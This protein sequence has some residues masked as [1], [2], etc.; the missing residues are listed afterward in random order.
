M[1]RRFINKIIII[2]FCFRNDD[3]SAGLA[4]AGRFPW[5]AAGRHRLLRRQRAGPL[6]AL[7]TRTQSEVRRTT[8]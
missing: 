5:L 6:L 2:C 1:R 7:Q 4:A 8:K 3:V